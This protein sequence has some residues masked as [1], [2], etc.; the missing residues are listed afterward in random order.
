MGPQAYQLEQEELDE[1]TVSFDQLQ[2]LV[3][4]YRASCDNLNESL[5]NDVHTTADPI[6]GH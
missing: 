1:L 2:K 5:A 4:V 3:D 6:T